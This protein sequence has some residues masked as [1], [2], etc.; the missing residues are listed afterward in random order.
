MRL[1]QAGI[2]TTL[3]LLFSTPLFSTE[4]ACFRKKPTD[5]QVVAGNKARIMCGFSG[6]PEIDV[7]W[8]KENRLVESRGKFHIIS[9]RNESTLEISDSEKGDS[10]TFSCKIQN[11]AGEDTCST[12]LSIL[13]PYV[14]QLNCAITFQIWGCHFQI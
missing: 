12:T 11:E 7:R 13:G 5:L 1:K 14:N 9:N 8:Y 2:I 4:P 3:T 10:G 6:T